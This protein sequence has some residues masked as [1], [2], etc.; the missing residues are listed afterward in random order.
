MDFQAWVLAC[1]GADTKNDCGNK[2]KALNL[3]GCVECSR[4]QTHNLQ[5]LELEMMI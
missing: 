2:D 4:A 1:V 5:P 3:R